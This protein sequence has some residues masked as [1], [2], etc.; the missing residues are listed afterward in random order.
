[1]PTDPGGRPDRE[2]AGGPPLRRWIP[3]PVLQA[4][5]L[6]LAV[7]FAVLSVHVHNPS[8][9]LGAAAVVAVLAI[10]AD[11]PLGILRLCSQTLHVRL[12]V[13]A[14]VLI[15]VAPVLPALRSDIEGILV[16]TVGAIGLFRLATLTRVQAARGGRR[17]RSRVDGPVIDATATVVPATP[18]SPPTDGPETSGGPAP[19]SI[20]HRAGRATAAGR[21]AVEQKGPEVGE[22]VRRGLRG[23]GRIAGRWTSDVPQDPRDRST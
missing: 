10:T 21:R 17:R 4:G 22:Q 7:T 1:M 3:F 16:T 9:L 8:L 12:V 13:V 23:A 11:G 14:A 5:E 19:E 6:G 20:L 2:P 15:A 18:P